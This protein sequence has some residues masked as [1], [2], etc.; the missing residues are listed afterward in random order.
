M[1]RKHSSPIYLDYA[2]TTPMHP[3]V[4]HAMAAFLDKR[5]YNPSSPYAAAQDVKKDIE[6]ARKGIA[7]W[8]GAKATEIIFTA[9]GTEANNL[10]IHGVMSQFPDANLIVSAIEHESVLEPA[11]LYNRKL[12]PVDVNGIVK[13]EALESLI[14]DSTVL[15][16]IMYANNEI[17]TIQPMPEIA[18]VIKRVRK[19][20]LQRAIKTPLYLHTDAAQA[21][22]LLDLHV[23]RLGIDLMMLNGSKMYGPKQVGCLY[24]KTDIHL[25]SLIQGGGQERGLR[26]GTENVAGII[27]LATALGRAQ[28]VRKET[29]DRE[30]ALIDSML[31]VLVEDVP[32]IRVNGSRAHR[33]S[34]NLSL[35]IPGVDGE[36]LVLELDEQG[37]QAATGSACSANRD[38]RSHVL[39]ALGLSEDEVDASLRITVGEPTGRSEAIQAARLIAATVKRMRR[40]AK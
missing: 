20:R 32:D 22:T 15:V 28:S 18:R 29:S 3:D 19:Q 37:V 16:S 4:V 12:A 10:A 6:A 40:K 26:S 7:H 33:L 17:G 27:G 38:T 5:F 35:T 24:I 13:L 21:A 1:A 2:A 8:L 9:G 11:A 30:A 36:R 34:S 14:D 39:I 23:D 31:K 25:A